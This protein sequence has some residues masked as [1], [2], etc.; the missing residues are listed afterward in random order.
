MKI[1]IT[2]MAHDK[3][4]EAAEALNDR[5]VQYPFVSNTIT[6]DE[7]NSEWH[8]GKRALLDGVGKGDYHVVLQDDAILTPNFYQNLENAINA[9][10][11]KT[12]ISLYTGTARPIPQR[13]TAAVNKAAD[14]DMLRFHQLMWGVGIAI[15][16]DHILPML[17]FV[18]NVDLQYDNKIGEFY[19]QNGLPVYYL[20]PSIVDHDDDTDSLLPGH[21]RDIDHEKRVAH[22]L[23]TGPISWTGKSHFI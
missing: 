5:L 7:I 14:G 2:I 3:R 23:A 12:L 10:D 16:T 19:C 4:T 20:I 6:W 17:E 18:E 1:S 13:V 8:T 9:L 11:Q 21:G 15:P 22:K